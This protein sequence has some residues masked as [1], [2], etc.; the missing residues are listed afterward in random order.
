M[1]GCCS[2]LAVGLQERGEVE[3]IEWYGV[4]ATS[5]V[6]SATHARAGGMS[7]VSATM[8]RCTSPGCVSQGG[9]T[10][11]TDTI[12]ELKAEHLCSGHHHGCSEEES[13]SA[14]ELCSGYVGY[15]SAAS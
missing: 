7:K 6:T 1:P 9:A 12:Y 11:E 15:K 5:S 10:T 14:T 2:R 13:S 3:G 8:E 4:W